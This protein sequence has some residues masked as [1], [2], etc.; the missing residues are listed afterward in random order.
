MRSGFRQSDREREEELRRRRRGGGQ[1]EEELQTE[2]GISDYTG[3]P[4]VLH[5][6]LSRP[7]VTGLVFTILP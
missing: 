1:E 6:I 2:E 3:N 7:R 4:W 5:V